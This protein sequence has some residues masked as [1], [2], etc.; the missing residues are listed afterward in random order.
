MLITE[1]E[2]FCDVIELD[3]SN[4]RCWVHF[5]D[6]LTGDLPQKLTEL[7]TVMEAL[8]DRRNLSHSS[9]LELRAWSLIQ[10]GGRAVRVQY[11]EEC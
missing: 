2:A 6:L 11:S 10:I 7:D 4:F 1:N 3:C 9:K 8:C 5:F